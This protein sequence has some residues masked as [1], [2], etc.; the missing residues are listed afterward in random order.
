MKKLL[1]ALL[2]LVLIVSVSACLNDPFPPNETATATATPV[3]TF[4]AQP[5]L[6][7]AATDTPMPIETP[8]PTP[9]PTATPQPTPTPLAPLDILSS[10]TNV[11]ASGGGQGTLAFDLD[12]DGTD[13]VIT[14]SFLGYG[15]PVP[16]GAIDLATP[17]MTM[18]GYDIYQCNLEINGQSII[19]QGEEM[20]GL[21]LIG[22]IDAADGQYEIM[23]PEFGPSGDPQTAFIAYSGIAPF[24]IGK[25]YQNPFLNLKVDGSGEIMGQNRGKKL[26]TWFY[27]AKYQID[28]GL[29]KET[30]EN[31]MVLMNSA[32]TAKVD[33]PLQISPVD[34]TPAFTLDAGE[35]ATITLTDDDKWFC[36]E[37]SGGLKG[38][39]EI[40]GFYS[41]GGVPAT[42]VF[43]GLSMAD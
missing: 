12:S 10:G 7:P 14:Y 1:I 18:M 31:G 28:N 38:W 11:Y 39:F 13:D 9:S 2:T 41:I 35:H 29:I 43:D 30:K 26:H 40:T 6:M 34:A 33:L 16:G 3:P 17:Y 42:D 37:K 4:S 20:A 36:V 21:I 24:S 23:I 19:V 25:I 32:I 22:D 5:T 15:G 27:D 8:T